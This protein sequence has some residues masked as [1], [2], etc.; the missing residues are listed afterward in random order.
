VIHQPKED[1]YD[2]GGDEVEKPRGV[3]HEADA[4]AIRFKQK[5]SEL[6]DK[7][8]AALKPLGP[9][10]NDPFVL[11]RGVEDLGEYLL[12][13]LGPVH[14]QYNLQ[15]DEEQAL[16]LLSSPVSGQFYYILSSSTGEFC[17]L[18]DG[19]ALEGLLVRDLI[20]QIYGVPQL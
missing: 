11:V 3:R 2:D 13:D 17:G 10:L 19:H 4:D 7:L 20:R 6:L 12:L 8:Y 9:P 15:V 14:G 5:S 18:D 16:V 1:S